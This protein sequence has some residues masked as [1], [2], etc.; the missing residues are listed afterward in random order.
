MLSEAREP[1]PKGVGKNLPLEVQ[2]PGNS[3][4]DTPQTDTNHALGL[5]F[6]TEVEAPPFPG[7]RFPR[8]MIPALGLPTL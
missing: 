5:C 3:H 6:L 8:E 1:W 7:S 4:Q 2:H